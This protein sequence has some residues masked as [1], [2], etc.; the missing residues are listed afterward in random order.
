MKILDP[1][2]LQ[3][4]MEQRAKHYDK[5][6]D[7]FTSLKRAFQEMIDLDDFEGK[8]AEAIKDIMKKVNSV[9]RVH[10]SHL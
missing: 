2:S 4:A 10:F 3:N 8:G 6:R 7:Q 1:S 5:L 9:N